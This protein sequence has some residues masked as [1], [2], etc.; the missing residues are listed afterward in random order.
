MLQISCQFH[1]RLQRC[2]MPGTIPRPRERVG[3]PL[4]GGRHRLQADRLHP[5]GQRP[6]AQGLVPEPLVLR[7]LRPRLCRR[8]GHCPRG[9]ESR[10][11][12]GAH[13]CLCPPRELLRRSV[14]S[15]EECRAGGFRCACDLCEARQHV[16]DRATGRQSTIIH[17]IRRIPGHATPANAEL[18]ARLCDEVD[19]KLPSVTEVS[20]CPLLLYFALFPLFF[21]FF[22]PGF[23]F[24]AQTAVYV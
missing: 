4:L 21:F 24:L 10:R 3:Q 23:F 22:C 8:R 2:F 18:I 16:A 14:R 17:D 11:G 12:H 20:P 9:Q 15:S 5:S 7:Q 19:A 6:L 1:H 13:R